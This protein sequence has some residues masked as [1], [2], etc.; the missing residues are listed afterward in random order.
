MAF[1]HLWSLSLAPFTVQRAA[2]FLLSVKHSPSQRA[3]F[4]FAFSLARTLGS[5]TIPLTH[6][7]PVAVA[8]FQRT[9]EADAPLT[10]ALDAINPGCSASLFSTLLGSETPSHNTLS[11]FFRGSDEESSSGD[12]RH[13]V[14]E[15]ATPLCHA[16]LSSSHHSDPTRHHRRRSRNSFEVFTPRRGC[17]SELQPDIGGDEEETGVTESSWKD[18]ESGGLFS[19]TTQLKAGLGPRDVEGV[20]GG[21]SPE[22]E[23]P[24]ASDK[25]FVSDPQ[26]LQ[27]G[28]GRGG[29]PAESGSQSNGLTSVF[30]RELDETESD[31]EKEVNNSNE[32]AFTVQDH[33][34][35]SAQ[36]RKR[37]KFDPDAVSSNYWTSVHTDGDAKTKC[38]SSGIPDSESS[39]PA[40]SDGHVFAEILS[41]SVPTEASSGMGDKTKELNNHP[42]HGHNACE[43]LH[44]DDPADS[45]FT[46]VEPASSCS[47]TSFLEQL[48]ASSTPTTSKSVLPKDYFDDD[49]DDDDDDDEGLGSD[50]G[51]SDDNQCPD[52]R[53][54]SSSAKHQA[55]SHTTSRV[56]ASGLG[57]LP[58]P[59]ASQS[60]DTCNAAAQLLSQSLRGIP[61]QG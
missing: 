51:S 54:A 60:S 48:R 18:T 25:S 34:Y 1:S 40:G 39:T 35:G 46:N 28:A 44:S 47:G 5:V 58:H 32:E 6:S 20:N 29:F 14:E 43:L 22:R 9:L 2:E 31:E 30:L 56:D 17:C 50:T 3:V 57:C 45:V 10:S 15:A 11:S 16:A 42:A 36:R 21:K 24:V 41:L 33:D 61:Y 59:T 52:N 49:D 4:K 13:S 37:I 23:E 55:G 38:F 19:A 27:Y 12:Q 8:E 7:F 26:D 53:N